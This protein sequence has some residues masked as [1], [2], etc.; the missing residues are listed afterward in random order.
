[1]VL[2]GKTLA[3]NNV[4]GYF[5][6]PDDGIVEMVTDVVY[7]EK[8][9]KVTKF[10]GGKHYYATVGGHEVYDTDGDRKWNTELYAYGEAVKFIKI[11]NKR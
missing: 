9:I 10:D 7:T 11:L 6:I 4:G 5:S 3:V 2:G 1:M 8:D